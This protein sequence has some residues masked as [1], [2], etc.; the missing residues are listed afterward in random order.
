MLI[1]ESKGLLAERVV[2]FLLGEDNDMKV[3][4]YGVRVGINL[5]VK[6]VVVRIRL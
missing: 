1:M 2:V 4:D 6:V 5:R 3:L